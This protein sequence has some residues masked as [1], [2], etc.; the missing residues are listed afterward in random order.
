MGVL[1]GSDA[2]KCSYEKGYVNR[3]AL[4]SCLTCKTKNGEPAGV[5]LACS[6]TCHENCELIELYTKRNF[7]CDCRTEKF[8]RPC[9]F[10]QKVLERNEKNLY[11]QNFDGKYCTCGRPYPDPDCPPELEDDE[12]IQCV[13]CE[14]W[15]HG[16]HLGLTKE[17]LES[18]DF[19]EL[20][21]GLCLNRND[22]KFIRKYSLANKDVIKSSETCKL[23]RDDNTGQTEGSIFSSTFRTDICQCPECSQKLQLAKIEFLCD[24]DDSISAYEAPSINESQEILQETENQINSFMDRLDHRGQVEI[25]HGMASLKDAMKAMIDA[26]GDD[27]IVGE[28]HVA[29]FKRKIQEDLEQRKRRRLELGISE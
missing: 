7:R 6:L 8:Q 18:D 17:E 14:D 11:G 9:Q 27:G 10:G 16:T 26:A 29:I 28:E 12:M 25:A 4:Y 21:C 2:E 5:C 19:E 20:I 1:G 3:Q 24:P 22:V 23:P 13:L 15:F